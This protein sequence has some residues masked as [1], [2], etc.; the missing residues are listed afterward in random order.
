[1]FVIP[2]NM[3][4]MLYYMTLKVTRSPVQFVVIVQ[5]QETFFRF[6]RSAPTTTISTKQKTYS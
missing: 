3:F 4:D 5:V 2:V 1:M 6:Y